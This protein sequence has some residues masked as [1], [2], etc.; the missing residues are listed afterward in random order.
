MRDA[1][2]TVAFQEAT[3]NWTEGSG[4]ASRKKTAIG[5]NPKYQAGESQVKVRKEVEGDNLGKA[6]AFTNVEAQN[7]TKSPGVSK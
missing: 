3:S 4:K 6:I 1:G 5:Y 2:G 7:T